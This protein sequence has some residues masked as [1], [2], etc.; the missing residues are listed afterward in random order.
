MLSMGTS[1]LDEVFIGNTLEF[2]LVLGK[3]REMNVDRGSH[4]CT[5]IGW[6]GGDE[7]EMIIAGELCN[8]LKFC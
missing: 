5:K 8:C 1:D 7:T 4:C 2:F 3:A 6:A